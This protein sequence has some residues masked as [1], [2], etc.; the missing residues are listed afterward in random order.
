MN[1]EVQSI[2]RTVAASTLDCFN[3]RKL[4]QIAGLPTVLYFATITF[5]G[6][7][8][9]PPPRHFRRSAWQR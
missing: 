1:I 6:A 8:W 9:G 3:Y 5:K 7:G 2:E 4:Q